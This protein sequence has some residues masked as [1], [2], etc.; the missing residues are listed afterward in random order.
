MLLS[1]LIRLVNYNSRV[2]IYQ[3]DKYSFFKEE[4]LHVLYISIDR[5]KNINGFDKL[6]LLYGDYEVRMVK[7]KDDF[8]EITIYKH[9]EEGN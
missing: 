3:S 9:T 2:I 6:E 8:L 7:S 5:D 1:E 4:D